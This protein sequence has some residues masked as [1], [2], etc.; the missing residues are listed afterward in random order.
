LQEDAAEMQFSQFA[1]WQVWRFLPEVS[2]PYPIGMSV[3]ATQ[4][5]PTGFRRKPDLHSVQVAESAA[6]RAQ[7]AVL[8][9]SIEVA[10]LIPYPPGTVVE[11]KQA[12][13]SAEKSGKA[14]WQVWHSMLF[15]LQVKQF[16]DE[17]HGTASKL[18]D[19][20]T[21]PSPAGISAAR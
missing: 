19:P 4:V 21:C 5:L 8:Q 11:L 1:T 17:S 14:G 18:V 6:H 10:F 15:A 3:E 12:L 13:R 2:G 20:V 9:D 16:L 7:L